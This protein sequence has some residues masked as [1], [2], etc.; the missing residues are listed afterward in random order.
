MGSQWSAAQ[1][2]MLKCEATTQT[3]ADCT[4]RSQPAML[5]CYMTLNA[6]HLRPTITFFIFQ[7]INQMSHMNCD[8]LTQYQAHMFI[9]MPQKP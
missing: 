5:K 8:V 9:S 2:K 6:R 7:E 4:V 1:Y 3:G